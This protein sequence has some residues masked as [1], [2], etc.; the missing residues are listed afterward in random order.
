MSVYERL[1]AFACVYERLRVFT[2]VDVCLRALTCVCGRL[3]VLTDDF[4]LF[5]RV[6]EWV[7]AHTSGAEPSHSKSS[8]LTQQT[9]L[10]P[11]LHQL[12]AT[13]GLAALRSRRADRLFTLWACAQ[14]ADAALSGGDGL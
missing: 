3:R 14:W 9:G 11:R 7:S 5:W 8:D 6:S 13:H 2:C 4:F 10:Q 12:N 1:R